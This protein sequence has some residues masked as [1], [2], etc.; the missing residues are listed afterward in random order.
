MAE[1][2]YVAQL[3]A[4]VTGQQQPKPELAGQTPAAAAVSRAAAKYQQAR[5]NFEA[6]RPDIEAG[7]L[8]AYPNWEAAQA[9]LEKLR[10]EAE[11][12][13][14]QGEGSGTAQ[15]APPSPAGK[16]PD[17]VEKLRLQVA[18]ANLG[19]V[20]TAARKAAMEEQTSRSITDPKMHLPRAV[21]TPSESLM[22]DPMSG[23]AQ[24]E[25][26]TRGARQE[27]GQPFKLAGRVALEAAGS[28]GGGVAGAAGKALLKKG[29]QSMAGDFVRGVGRTVINPVTGRAFGTAFGSLL[30]QPFDP[31]EDP[32]G[33]AAM[34]G[35]FSGLADGVLAAFGAA[36]AGL[37]LEPSGVPGWRSTRKLLGPGNLPSPGRLS[38]SRGVDLME[39][40]VENSIVGG[41]AVERRN[42]RAVMRARELLTGYIDRFTRGATRQQVDDLVRSVTD[43]R[44]GA[45]TASAERLYSKVDELAPMGVDTQSLV[46]LRNK[47]VQEYQTGDV[48][49]GM[50]RLVA[51][52]DRTL[53][54]PENLRGIKKGHMLSAEPRRVYDETMV[55]DWRPPQ[56]GQLEPPATGQWVQPSTDPFPG[57]PG[58]PWQGPVYDPTPVPDWRAPGAS[59]PGQP[60]GNWAAPSTDPFPGTP[61][62]PWRGNW[63]AP[64]TDPFPGTPGQTPPAT[65]GSPELPVPTKMSPPQAPPPG[66]PVQIPQSAPQPMPRG[67][68]PVQIPQGPMPPG[69]AGRGAPGNELLGEQWAELPPSEAAAGTRPRGWVEPTPP[70]PG[71]PV[72]IPQSPRG[73]RPGRGAPGNELL[74]EQ[75]S[76]GAPPELPLGSRPRGW[77]D[78]PPDFKS[79]IPFRDAQKLRSDM[80]S[81]QRDLADPFPGQTLGNA[82]RVTGT[83][84]QA[85]ESAAAGFDNPEAFQFWRLA[86]QFWKDGADAFGESVMKGLASARPDDLF[87]LIMQDDSPQQIARFRKLILGGTGT[88]DDTARRIRETAERTLRDPAAHPLTKEL[89]Q[90]RL[91]GLA[92]GEEVWQTFQGRF[93]IEK[94]RGADPGAGISV[95]GARGDRMVS[96]KAMLS[97]WSQTGDE[98]LRE[99]F[100]KAS[101]RRHAERLMRALETAQA[102]TGYAGGK[103]GAQLLQF[104]SLV[105]FVMS[106]NVRNTFNAGMIIIT[107]KAL[108]KLLDDERFINL[109]ITGTKLKPG[110]MEGVRNFAQ[111][112]LVASRA[113]ARIID[114]EGNVVDPEATTDAQKQFRGIAGSAYRR[115][116][117]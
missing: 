28:Y 61:G 90:M 24:A 91:D 103:L 8:S 48:P 79:H 42:Q 21:E 47:I 73:V 115:G 101:Q 15:G 80:L 74:G 22:A 111:L 5:Q 67:P 102:D 58:A 55:P 68:G 9:Q 27:A 97:S 33:T 44:H 23:S 19:P 53:G 6:A 116:G 94:L 104:G 108:G 40:I 75:W 34:S 99:I 83:V 52:I 86:N 13:R 78:A 17:F 87:R 72:Q 106:M 49:E 63:T 37:Q 4:Q 92:R 69:R 29:A 117:P 3:R 16:M 81:A 50:N 59:Q 56:R 112:A 26:A 2:D 82:K 14:L 12:T 18:D 43:E 66:G 100:P 25:I 31:V 105:N 36:R 85:I 20:P 1:P 41:A 51:S 88:S 60:G 77:V 71:G 76:Q 89:A 62:E 32:Y 7:K 64:S 46:A 54:V 30:S 93:L 11:S 84:D 113:G 95:P 110:S 98:T 114:H 38:T 39:N 35:G 109:V 70:A 45:F 57:T 65:A 10:Q 96:G 107:P